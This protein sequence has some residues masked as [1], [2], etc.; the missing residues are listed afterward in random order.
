MFNTVKKRGAIVLALICVLLCNCCIYALAQ[1]TD[2]V[3]VDYNIVRSANA[4]SVSVKMDIDN[5]GNVKAIAIVSGRRNTTNIDA[6]LKLQKYNSK[7]KKWE[8]LKS[9]S[10]T[11]KATSTSFNVTHKLSQKGTYR[12]KLTAKVTNGGKVENESV[13]SGKKTY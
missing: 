12:C 10:K 13:V 5:A 7:T 11:Q 3:S 6:T 8:T 4:N 9:W 2:I 1:D